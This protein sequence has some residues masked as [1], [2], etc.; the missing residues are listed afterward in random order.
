MA[1]VW[2]VDAVIGENGGFYFFMDQNNQVLVKH[3]MDDEETRAGQRQQLQNILKEIL[4]RF[5]KPL[6]PRTSLTVIR[7]RHRLLG[8]CHETIDGRDNED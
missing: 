4:N 7:Y 6:R 3:F 5:P 8:R 1:R 2:P